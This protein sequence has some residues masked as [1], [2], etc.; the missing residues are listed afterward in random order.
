M[1]GFIDKLKDFFRL[2]VPL[3]PV[4]MIFHCKPFVG[5]SYLRRTCTDIN[6]QYLVIICHP[7]TIKP[8]I[9]NAGALK[10]FH[11]STTLI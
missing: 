6:T 9:I 2:R 7:R 4:G 1:V 10:N 8:S 3:I 5:C 11:V